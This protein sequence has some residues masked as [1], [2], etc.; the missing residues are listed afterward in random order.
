MDS[1]FFFNNESRWL[2]PYVLF[3]C[4]VS[5]ELFFW[6]DSNVYLFHP[7]QSGYW[8]LTLYFKPWRIYRKLLQYHG[9]PYQLVKKCM[10]CQITLLIVA[11]DRYLENKKLFWFHTYYR[12]RFVFLR[13]DCYFL[14]L[15]KTR[16][17][18]DGKWIEL[19]GVISNKNKRW[20]SVLIVSKLES[21][22]FYWK[23]KILK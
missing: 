5:E 22:Y 7:N 17:T 18:T 23:W 4:S 9:L 3:E 19:R 10:F 12:I 21:K 13:H 11:A 2:G 16:P 6:P 14:W 20:N 1:A 15:K 8:L